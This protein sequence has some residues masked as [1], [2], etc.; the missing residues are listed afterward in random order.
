MKELIGTGVALVTP[1]TE[2]GQVDHLALSRLVNYQIENGIDYLVVLGTTGEAATL[3]PTEK[4][5]VMSTVVR[6]N[7]ERLP[8]VA[9]IGGNN[10][11]E[12]VKELK[13]G[14]FNGFS[15]ILS[16][17]PYYNKPSQEGIY[18]HFE[19]VAINSPLPVIVYNVPPRTGSNMDACTSLR[20]ARDFENIVAIKEAAGNFDQALELLRDKPDDFHVIS[21]EDML[22]LPMVLAG[23]S[24]VIS[25]IG[26]GLPK[27][28][29]EMIKLGREGSSA[30]AYVRF[31]KLMKSME[32][33]FE[34]GNPSGIKC[35]LNVLNILREEVR[36]PLVQASNELREK[37]IK[38]VVSYK[39][40]KDVI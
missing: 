6:S 14:D 30:E 20:L 24:G 2:E 12:V 34:E 17:S 26:Q 22:A 18:K 23:A 36:L 8:L 21:G 19:A 32:L 39:K 35:L 5:E 27:E 10:T 15:A 28:F 3:S 31:F 38:F 37:M 33:I 29:S 9:G 1:F 7:S 25:V 4:A 11:A 40:A 13:T 16:V